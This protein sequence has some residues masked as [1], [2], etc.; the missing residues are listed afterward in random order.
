[1]KILVT[2]ASGLLGTCLMD[3]LAEDAPCDGTCHANPAPGLLPLDVTNSDAVRA[4]IL[5][6]RYTHVIH[7]AAE[8]DPDRCL[9]DP[10]HA[11]RLN[12]LG[13]ELVAQTCRE[14][15]ARLVYISTDYVFDGNTPP[16]PEDAPPSPV[17]VYGR[18]KLA[19][20]MAARSVP[21][22]LIVRIP[23]LYTL[24]LTDPRNV[25]H[26]FAALVRGGGVHPQDGE[27]VRYYTRADDVARGVRFAL[28]NAVG[29][30]LHLTADQQTT[31]ADFLRRLAQALGADPACAPDGPPPTTGDVRPHNSRLD[32]AHYKRLG[33]PAFASIDAS[34][35]QLPQ[36]GV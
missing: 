10:A 5:E 7:S 27:T 24:D 32:N 11:Y 2:G 16:Y 23:A 21:G 18:T 15:G 30:I 20:E 35:A 17:N 14:A 36:A 9:R 6:G 4:R 1:M 25:L 8:R 13:S 31:K 34:F 3:A 12:A 28:R 33:G 26:K 22:S 29:G 19:G